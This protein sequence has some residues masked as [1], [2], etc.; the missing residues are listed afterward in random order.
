MF[1]KIYFDS[2]ESQLVFEI[3][4]KPIARL[5]AKWMGFRA[6]T[7]GFS[8]LRAID[9]INHNVVG[10]YQAHDLSIQ[11]CATNVLVSGVNVD[12]SDYLMLIGALNDY[13]D[14]LMPALPSEQSTPVMARDYKTPD[15]VQVQFYRG[16]HSFSPSSIFVDLND[17]DKMIASAKAAS[18]DWSYLPTTARSLCHAEDIQPKVLAELI[19]VLESAL[20]RLKPVVVAPAP[21]I[22]TSSLDDTGEFSVVKNGATIVH[23][24]LP[25]GTARSLHRALTTNADVKYNLKCCGNAF[26]KHSVNGGV[27]ITPGSGGCHQPLHIP[28]D[29]VDSVR[30]TMLDFY[31][32]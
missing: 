20:G 15:T 27:Y 28:A 2:F 32:E 25:I 30:K 24:I 29:C 12:R 16:E 17:G 7:N 19:P 18:G 8:A 5:T 4:G 11:V 31:T 13:K 3:S 21:D 22:I 23:L 9:A 14:K 10:T 26:I 6:P 1:S